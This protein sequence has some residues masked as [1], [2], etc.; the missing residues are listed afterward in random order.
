MWGPGEADG[1]FVFNGAELHFG[2]MKTFWGRRMVP[3]TQQCE[4]T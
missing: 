1:D 4:C 3:V 2:T